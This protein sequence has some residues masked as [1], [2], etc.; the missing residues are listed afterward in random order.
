MSLIRASV[1]T[2]PTII[3]QYKENTED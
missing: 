1:I 3:G 2:H